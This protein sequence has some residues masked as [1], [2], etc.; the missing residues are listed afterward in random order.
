[1]ATS[2]L[3]IEDDPNIV[4]L[5]SWQFSKQGYDVAVQTDGAGGLAAALRKD[6]DVIL[7][8]VMLPKLNGIDVCSELRKGGVQSAI[9]ML[10]CKSDEDDKVLG[11]EAGADDY[12]LKPFSV[13]ELTARIK[14]HMRRIARLRGGARNN[15][16]MHVM[17]FPGLTLDASSRVVMA[18]DTAVDLTPLEFDLLHYLASNPGRAF[19][20]EDLLNAVWNYDFDGYNGTVSSHISRVRTKIEADPA[21][22]MYIQTVWGVGYKFSN[23]IGE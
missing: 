15:A 3:L 23:D 18:R 19:T 20:R 5:I 2:L 21:N 22:P 4:K 14:A 1:M 10:T 6:Y 17:R 11:F 8:D 16:G 7:L 9:L 12:V 13:N